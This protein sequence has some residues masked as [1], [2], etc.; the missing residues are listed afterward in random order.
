MRNHKLLWQSSYDRGLNVLLK[1]WPEIIKKYPDVEL[2][3]CYGWQLFDL[4]TKSNPERQE[5]KTKMVEL[6]KQKGVKDHGRIGKDELQKL[7]KECGILAYCS[8]FSE[9]FCIS[10][11]EASMDG[12]VPVTT[13]IGAL[14]EFT[15]GRVVVKGDIYDFEVQKE[16]LKQL[17]ALMGDVKRWH[18]LRAEGQEYAKQF[19]WDKVAPKWLPLFE[20]HKQ[21][22][23][24]SIVTPT[25]RRGWWNIMANNLANQTY[26]NFEWVIVDD[27]KDDRSEIAREYAKK[28]SLD[29]RY[30]RGK[31]RS[32]KRNYGLVN[33]DNT[34]LQHVTGEIY[35]C[36]Q[37]F[38]LIPETG[39]EDIVNI[40]RHHPNAL[41]ALPDTYYAPKIKPDTT[42]EDW[43]N[44]DL[45][46]KGEFMRANARLTNEGFRF[47]ERPFD[48][49]QNY[50]AIPMHILK[51]LGG[52][53]EFFDFGLG[54]NNTEL[55]FRALQK[56]YKIIIDEEN[57]A[58]CIDHWK[59]LEG[60]PEHGLLRE[61]RLNDPQFLWMIQMIKDGKL[62]LKR[63]QEIDDKINLTYEMP[64]LGQQDAV[65][66]IRDNMDKIVI[67]WGNKI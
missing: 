5:W 50:G 29:I 57:I 63:T 18:L 21:D 40:Y 65:E 4:I 31:E 25:N 27:Y 43:F 42:K 26:K 30:F 11:M 35:V 61:R 48:F 46:V 37:D 34:A 62:P 9:I 60:T 49:E 38:I 33:A 17:L 2:H 16:Y 10:A 56:G 19:T 7:R 66:W 45:D 41:Q 12:C 58:T 64:E 15:T 44:G 28:Y 13:D 20:P 54:F 53:W 51:E 6:M 23:K 47:T 67:G 55:S 8:D 1:L 36:L 32:I 52:W 14:G 3:I 24:V 59:T 39:I 22:I